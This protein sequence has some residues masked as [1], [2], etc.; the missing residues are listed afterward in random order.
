LVRGT[1]LACN[2]VSREYLDR[3]V[4]IDDVISTAILLY[5]VSIHGLEY[6]HLMVAVDGD[7][8]LYVAR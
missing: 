7:R 2:G 5:L 6:V 8:Y 3:V 1:V 4:S